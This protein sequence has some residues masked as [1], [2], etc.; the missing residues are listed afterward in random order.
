MV[1]NNKLLCVCDGVGGWA[2]HGVDAGKYSKKLAS[3]I[4]ELFQKTP[5]TYIEDPKSIII[6]AHTLTKEIGS[7]TC[8]VLTINDQDENNLKTSYIGDSG[9]VI[10]RKT[11]QSTFET[12]YVSEEQQKSF[13]FPYQIGSEGDNPS[14]SLS[15]EHTVNHNDLIVVGTD[16]I[17]DNIDEK[18]ILK[19]IQPFWESHD[20]IPDLDIVAEIISKY[21]YKL[22]LDPVYNSPF[23]KKARKA[24]LDFAGGKSDDITVCV[25]QVKLGKFQNQQQQQ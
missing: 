8:C 4:D 19:C 10:Y 12:I 1:H 22:S 20:D 25:A 7:T 13:N 15:F 11:S 3:H 6:D 14:K 9:Y 16:G 5:Q 21:A 23:T 2:N 18:Q 24:F 17:F